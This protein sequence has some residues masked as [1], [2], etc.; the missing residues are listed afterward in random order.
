MTPRFAFAFLILLIFTGP[1]ALAGETSSA[2][3][4]HGLKCSSPIAFSAPTSAGLDALRVIH[5]ADAKSGGEKMSLIA[6]NFSK[7]S[8]MSDAELLEYV[9]TTF[10]AASTPGK[11]V[12][13]TV[14]GKKVTGQAMEKKIPSPSLTEIY[15]AT[16]KNGNKVVI[17]F[18]FI[19]TFS[20]EAEKAIA[21]ITA[22]MKE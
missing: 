1:P 16:K 7:D 15:V 17:G 11:P 19:P 10:L 6:V 22:T 8:G 3:E 14:L 20:K 12:A 5:P 18:V 2:I 13:R 4:F 21:G 9:G